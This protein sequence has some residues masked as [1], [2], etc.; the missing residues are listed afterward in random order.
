MERT[1]FFRQNNLDLIAFLFS[2]VTRLR[3][4]QATGFLIF[5]LNRVV[6][7]LTMNRNFLGRIDTQTDLN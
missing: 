6:D 2:D 5:E 4:A 1:A 3:R 7:F